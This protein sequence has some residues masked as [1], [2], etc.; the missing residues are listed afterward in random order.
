M[1]ECAVRHG[2]QCC[3]NRQSEELPGRGSIE[4]DN[5]HQSCA[6]GDGGGDDYS[7]TTGRRDPG[8]DPAMGRVHGRSFGAVS[9]IGETTSPRDCAVIQ[10][11]SGVRRFSFVA[12][13]SAGLQHTMRMGRVIVLGALVP[14]ARPFVAWWAWWQRLDSRSPTPGK[15]RTS[16]PSDNP[17]AAAQWPGKGSGHDHRAVS[18]TLSSTRRATIGGTQAP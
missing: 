3:H 17:G 6:H 7:L 4:S 9:T 8:V 14:L 11:S 16:G 5:D 1:L 2:R 18:K 12:R 13:P 10:C 15:S